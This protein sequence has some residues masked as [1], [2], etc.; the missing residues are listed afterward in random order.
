MMMNAIA[1][2]AIEAPHEVFQTVCAVLCLFVFHMCVLVF[3][4]CL[5]CA[6]YSRLDEMGRKT[7]R[8]H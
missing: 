1:T 2:Q 6:C 7:A 5:L 8:R 4:D 3:S